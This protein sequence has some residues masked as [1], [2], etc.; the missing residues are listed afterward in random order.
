PSQEEVDLGETRPLS[1]DA[2]PALDHQIV[3]L[4]GAERR[5]VQMNWSPSGRV[6]ELSGVVDHL[7]DGQAVE[8]KGG[9]K[10]QNLPQ[11]DSKR[12]DTDAM[13]HSSKLQSLEFTG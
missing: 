3:D 5:T 13:T 1:L 2:V 9:S 4:S 10:C 7:F 11:D 8:R 6:R 12:P